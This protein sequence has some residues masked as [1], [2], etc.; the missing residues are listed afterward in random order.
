[1]VINFFKLSP[2]EQHIQIAPPSLNPAILNHKMERT[3]KQAFYFSPNNI[4]V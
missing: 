2:A 3:D 4:K 1:M